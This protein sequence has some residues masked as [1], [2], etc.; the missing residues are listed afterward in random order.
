MIFFL[1]NLTPTIY[2]I[3]NFFLLLKNEIFS[4]HFFTS[5]VHFTSFFSLQIFTSFFLLQNFHFFFFTSNFHFSLYYKKKLIPAEYHPL[6]VCGH[7]YFCEIRSKNRLQRV[8]YYMI[9]QVLS[10]LP[11][12]PP[13]WELLIKYRPRAA[14]LWVLKVKLSPR[15]KIKNRAKYLTPRSKLIILFW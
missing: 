7:V 14:Q 10:P 6:I 13:R 3:I 15:S 5:N 12:P 11:L 9:W 4:L 1:K 2:K 8:L